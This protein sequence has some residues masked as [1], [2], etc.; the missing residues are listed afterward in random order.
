MNLFNRLF[1]SILLIGYLVALGAGLVLVWQPEEAI[2]ASNDN[3]SLGFDLNFAT[4]SEKSL[5]TIAI[6]ALMLPAAALLGAE[7]AA[8]G[9][10]EAVAT[11]TD[12][13]PARTESPRPAPDHTIETRPEAYPV[14]QTDPPRRRRFFGRA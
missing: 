11:R 3:Y 2:E 1:V 10:R 7:V 8:R 5:A 4:D 9:R 13:G 6:V 12:T 14:E